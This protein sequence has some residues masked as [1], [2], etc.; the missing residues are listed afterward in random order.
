MRYRLTF[1]VA[2]LLLLPSAVRSVQALG[3]GVIEGQV[4]DGSGEGA[5]LQG[6]PVTLSIFAGQDVESDLETTT[7]A[8]GRFRFEDLET[9]GHAYQ[10]VV[11]YV[12]VRYGSEVL[13]FADGQDHIS[14]PFTVFEATTSDEELSVERAHVILDFE[15]GI[16]KVQEVQILSNAGKTTYVGRTGEEG[17]ATVQFSLPE[18]ATAVQLVEGL[19]DCCVIETDTGL[20][21]TLPVYPGMAQFVFTYEL[22]PHARTYDLTRHTAYRTQS[23]D[24]LVADVAVHVTADGLSGGEETLSLQSG[25]YVHLAGENLAAGGDI[26]L[27]FANLP[28]ET[29][30]TQP[31]GDETPFY[32]WIVMGV[33][34]SGT[35]AYLAYPFLSRSKET[36]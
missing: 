12:G 8:E 36:A 29:T 18:G 13:A 21:S 20:A 5:P 1:F 32:V 22:H 6:L 35:A 26:A 19:K 3:S 14:V 4:S 25:D 33:I 27:H 28:V 34:I 31:T 9:E 23:L 17:E 24:V 7:D 10:F 11:D 30:P 15:P 2:I 16:I